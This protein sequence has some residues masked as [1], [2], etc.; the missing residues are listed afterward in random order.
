[1][2]TSFSGG[3]SLPI[4]LLRAPS[5]RRRSSMASSSFN[6]FRAR[7]ISSSSKSDGFLSAFKAFS[8]SAGEENRGMSCTRDTVPMK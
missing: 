4:T 8:S 5:K 6:S 2:P 1:M 3:A 7:E